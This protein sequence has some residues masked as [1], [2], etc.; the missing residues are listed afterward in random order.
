VRLDEKTHGPDGEGKLR[1]AAGRR[2][3]S[4]RSIASGIAESVWAQTAES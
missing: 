1:G 2:K 3:K 4:D